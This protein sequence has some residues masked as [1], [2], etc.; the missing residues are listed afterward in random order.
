MKR[1]PYDERL[2]VVLI[3]VGIVLYLFAMTMFVTAR[4]DDAPLP[5]AHC[6]N[7]DGVYHSSEPSGYIGA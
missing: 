3:V 4:G 5:C 1:D 2:I 6:D 7:V